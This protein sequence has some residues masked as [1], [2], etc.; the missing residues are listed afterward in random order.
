MNPALSGGAGGMVGSG[1]MGRGPRDRL[2]GVSVMVIKG[3]NKGY[4]GTVKD[5]NGPHVRVE[6][7]TGNKVITIDKDRIRR[8][9]CVHSYSCSCPESND[10]T[11]PDGSLEPLERPM[12][13]MGPPRTF[14]GPGGP[15][16]G[17]TQN[18]YNAGGGRTPGWGANNTGRT[19]NPYNESRTPAWAANSRT[20][21][22]YA[23]HG[24]TP[25]WDATA[26]TPNPYTQGGGGKTPAWSS[27]AKTPNPY[28]NGGGSSTWGGATPGRPA[29][30]GW[31]AWVCCNIFLL[32]LEIAHDSITGPSFRTDTI[33]VCVHTWGADAGTILIHANPWR[34]RIP[35]TCADVKFPANTRYYGRQPLWL[36]RDAIR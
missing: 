26:R 17:Q 15:G 30:G 16:G 8:R 35:D 1:T 20:P 24:K 5:T 13:A 23:E 18:P 36:L 9:K 10:P 22:P 25:A 7:L 6:L 3:P 2:I 4:V 11:S 31:D 29:G 34:V 12:A 21:N 19:P 28:A 32:S 33:R 14:G 27:S